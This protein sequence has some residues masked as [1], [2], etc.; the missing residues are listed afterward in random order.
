LPAQMV[1][2]I[3]SIGDNTT[4]VGWL[5]I[6]ARDHFFRIRHA[7][8]T[9]QPLSS[10]AQAALPTGMRAVHR[11]HSLIEQGEHL[12]SHNPVFLA[13]LSMTC[14]PGSVVWACCR[15]WR[16]LAWQPHVSHIP[17]PVHCL[18]CHCTALAYAFSLAS[19]RHPHPHLH[20]VGLSLSLCS[21]H[22]HCAGLGRNGGAS[23]AL[24]TATET[25]PAALPACT[26]RQPPRGHP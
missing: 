24:Q 8:P 18:I 21:C 13:L 14:G 6:L 3:H 1:V 23:L 5:I 10:R 7:H 20:H 17:L 25:W 22:H 15:G 11:L 12:Q 9:S 19:S 4:Y 16:P 2:S 26:A